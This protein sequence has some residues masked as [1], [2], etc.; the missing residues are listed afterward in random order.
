MS[1]GAAVRAAAARCIAAVL[2]GS[3]LDA[4]LESGAHGVDGRDRALLQ[5][6]CYGT[7]RAWPR[8]DALINLALD[9]PLRRREQELRAL[10]AVGLYQ[11]SDT[12]IPEH[13]AVNATVAAC[14]S[15]NRRGARG[16]VNALLRRYLR[17][18]PALLAGLDAAAAAA[19]PGW[20]WEAL[21]RDW[22]AQRDAIAAAAAARPP[23]TLRVNRRRRRRDDY[24]AQ[25]TGAGIGARP[26]RLSPDAVILDEGRGVADLPGFDAG[27][28]SVQDEAA[29]LAAH[30]LDPR[31]GERLLDA[32][33]A[34]G[35]KCCH[36]LELRPEIELLACDSSA[37][38][39]ARVTDNARRLGLAVDT[40]CADLRS[41]PAALAA[42][43]PFDAILADVPCSATGVIRRHP[44][45]K[46]LR[47]A[48][49]SAAFAQ[50]QRD[51]LAGC[52]TLLRPGGRLL[53]V[54]CSVLAAENG[55][56]VNAFLAGHPDARAEAL[57]VAGSVPCTPGTQVLP[58]ANGPDGLYFAL[59]RKAV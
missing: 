52:W 53:Y 35:G 1:S 48:S 41:P 18:G 9:R 55:D 33:A 14:A 27:E 56:V 29:Q 12:R 19:V 40:L 43:G 15:L 37:Q 45:I 31:A 21:G 49:D 4:A 2:R 30:L 57:T 5:E 7:L 24:L 17:E 46:L 32:C 22:P 36:L 25:L 11:L 13:A 51:I 28:V 38:R 20:L 23:L 6:L 16:L 47:R 39:L 26:G 42:A 50:Q 59:L 34:P 44:D 3:T 8:L 58:A 54:T 10:L